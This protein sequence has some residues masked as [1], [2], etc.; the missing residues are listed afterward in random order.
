MITVFFKIISVLEDM[1]FLF[2]MHIWVSTTFSNDLERHI[3]AANWLRIRYF[4][5]SR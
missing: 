5:V 2:F 3:S 4:T 1:A